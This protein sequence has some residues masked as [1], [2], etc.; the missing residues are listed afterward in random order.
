MSG[1]LSGTGASDIYTYTLFTGTHNFILHGPSNADFD[2]Y[3][4][5]NNPL[6]ASSTSSTS[7]EEIHY[8]GSANKVRVYSYSGSGSYTLCYLL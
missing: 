3:L 7:E 1:S 5:R 2:L 8:V 4:Y 6:K